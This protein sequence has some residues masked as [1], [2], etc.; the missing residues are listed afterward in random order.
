MGARPVRKHAEPERSERERL[1][2]PHAVHAVD[3]RAHTVWQVLDLVAVRLCV[4]GWVDAAT[5][6]AFGVGL[7]TADR[8]QERFEAKFVRSDSCWP[9]LGART[10]KGYGTFRKDGRTHYAHRV[11]Y[12]KSVGPI[13]EGLTIDHLCGNKICVN[14]AHLDVV[15]RGEN[16][17]RWAATITHCPQGHPYDDENTCVRVDGQ[18]DC[19]SCN[20]ERMRRRAA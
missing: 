14:P 15:T 4:R 17:R 10:K 20:R 5:R 13:P 1:E 16:I 11:A 2:R 6:Q 12:E 7:L 19:R 3:V 9:W 8:E 18:R